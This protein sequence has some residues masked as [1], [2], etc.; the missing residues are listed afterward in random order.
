MALMKFIVMI[1][2]SIMLNILCSHGLGLISWMIVF[3]PFIFNTRLKF[4]INKLINIKYQ[5]F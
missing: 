5:I 1:I 4:L 3:I 2:I